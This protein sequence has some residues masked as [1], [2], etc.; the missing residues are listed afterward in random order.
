MSS[1]RWDIE[2]V[3]VLSIL[4]ALSDDGTYFVPEILDLSQSYLFWMRSLT[5]KDDMKNFMF[6]LV[7]VLSILDALSDLFK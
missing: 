5:K 1:I 7:A 6:L 2:N 3:A 4:D